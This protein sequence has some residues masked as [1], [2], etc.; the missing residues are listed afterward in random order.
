MKTGGGTF[1][2]KN[3]RER[4]TNDEEEGGGGEVNG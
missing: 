1:K 2:G 3:L 4:G